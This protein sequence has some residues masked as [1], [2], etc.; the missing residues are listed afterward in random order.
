M[1]APEH[2]PPAA[3][4]ER[5]GDRFVHLH[6]APQMAEYDAAADRVAAGRHAAVLDWGC[7][8][9]QMTDLL[10]RRGRRDH[11]VR[12]PPHRRG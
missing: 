3:K 11:L 5:K 1:S 8:F 2:S 4:P 6:S 7:G 10:R 12:L 9:G